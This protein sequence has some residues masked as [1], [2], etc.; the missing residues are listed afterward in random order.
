MRNGVKATGSGI[1]VNTKH[2][3]NQSLGFLH[4][5]IFNFSQEI[6]SGARTRSRIP[7]QPNRLSPTRM[8]LPPAALTRSADRDK[9]TDDES[10]PGYV[11]L[12]LAHS[13]FTCKYQ[14]CQKNEPLVVCLCGIDFNKPV[15]S[16][17]SIVSSTCRVLQEVWWM[18]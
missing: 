5:Y 4:I 15:V 1:E 18:G 12:A 16:M 8:S 14:V 3:E 13:L 7:Q 11:S 17:V 6:E 2:G 9:A 10:R